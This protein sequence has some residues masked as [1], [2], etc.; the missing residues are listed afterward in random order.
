MLGAVVCFYIARILGRPAVDRF[1]S[2]KA[3]NYVD[4]FFER[5]G[6]NSVL[7]A[8]LL[9]VVSFDAVS[10]MAGLTKI[11]LW[12]FFWASAIGELPA[13]IVYSWL[14]KNITT[15]AKLGLWA[16]C[17]VAALVALALIV[18]RMLNVRIK[19]SI[20]KGAPGEVK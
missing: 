18:K 3:L 4:G 6:N 13:T 8:R 1:V 2:K 7:I 20:E 10:Y 11:S 9:P 14:G 5:Y 16:F 12:G 17:G 15:I 19:K